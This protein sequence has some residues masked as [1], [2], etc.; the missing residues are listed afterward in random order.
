VT[1]TEAETQAM[2]RALVAA[3]EPAHRISPNPRVGCVLLGADGGVLA[4]GRH[5]GPGTA[6]A[7]VDA[8]AQV[9]G[10]ARGA[11]AVVTLEP[12]DHTGRTGPCTDALLDAGVTRVVHA[13]DDPDPVAGG[14][15]S[16]LRA[17]GVEVESGVL[18]DEARAL[19]TR[20]LSAVARRR[21]FVT[22][23][24]AASLD[25][26]SAAAD[27]SSRWITGPAA[28]RDVQRL[29]AAADAVVVGTGTA[30]ADDPRLTVRDDD[31]RDLPHDQQPVR[32]VVGRR[33][34][35]AGSRLLDGAAPTLHL[36]T[37]DPGIVLAQLYERDV[38]EVWLEGGPRLAGAF[39]A[40]GLVDEVV[41]YV[42]PVL[43]GAGPAALVHAGVATIA[44]A[45]RLQVSDVTVI[46]GDV[47]IT[48]TPTREGTD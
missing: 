12:C 45:L 31:D 42:A 21:P 47:R 4:V 34:L 8:L 20:W 13:I 28:R 2:R 32:V 26:R 5:R 46:D 1:V 17:A 33:A 16:T 15:A 48:A 22:W 19:N 39:C 41:A 43:L 6:H 18:A 38:R 29:R 23:K 7:E 40:A 27:G 25:G 35:P 14:G 9:G 11:T 30:L 3:R 24:L 37:D 36:R 44:D 10:R